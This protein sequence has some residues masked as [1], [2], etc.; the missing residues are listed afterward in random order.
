M[1][2]DV[3]PRG[4]PG[5]PAVQQQS[6]AAHLQR[7]L[8]PALQW[9]V[10]LPPAAQHA[11]QCG[12][13]ELLDG[14]RRVPCIA[15]SPCW[16][17]PGVVCW[18]ALWSGRLFCSCLRLPGAAEVTLLSVPVDPGS[19]QASKPVKADIAWTVQVATATPPMCIMECRRVTS[20]SRVN[21]G[22]SCL[23]AGQWQ[24]LLPSTGPRASAQLCRG[25]RLPWWKS[26]S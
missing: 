13:Q 23:H 10:P 7:F 25:R 12:E 19:R 14:C 4:P 22:Q 5:N 21:A 15:V 6:K 20:V 24:L 26:L 16:Q 18:R 11:R 1:T 9:L 8:W 2:G 3:F 17:F